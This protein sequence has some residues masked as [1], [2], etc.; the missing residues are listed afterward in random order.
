MALAETVTLRVASYAPAG[1]FPNALIVRPFL[2]AV[3]AESEGTLAYQFF[4]GGTL[5]RN[6]AEQLRLVQDGVADMALVLTSFTPGELDPYGVI[7]IPGLIHD[8][9]EGSVLLAEAY[10]AGLLPT[11]DR[12][13]MV[14]VFST[15]VNILNLRNPVENLDGLAGLRIR[16]VGRPQAGAVELLGAVAIGNITSPE[17]AEAISRGTV[18]GAVMGGGALEAFRA[19]EVVRQHIPLPMGAPTFLLP[20]NQ[21]TWDALPEPARAAFERLGGEAFADFAGTVFTEQG[22]LS[23][24]RNLA[25]EGHVLLALDEAAMADYSARMQSLGEEFAARGPAFRAVYESALATL[26]RLRGQ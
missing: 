5:G 7:E 16:A 23:M 13:H 6:P 12:T 24:Q 11:P 19:A 18:D 22:N 26:E 1:S 25:L 17:T 4:E 8:P 20:M 9:Y 21:N 14:G 15:D 10:T 3:V 2:D